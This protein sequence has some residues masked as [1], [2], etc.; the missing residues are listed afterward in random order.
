[1]NDAAPTIGRQIQVTVILQQPIKRL[2]TIQQ[3]IFFS[4]QLLIIRLQATMTIHDCAQ[5]MRETQGLL[6]LSFRMRVLFSVNS[7][8]IFQ[9]RFF[10]VLNSPGLHFSQV[11]AE[12]FLRTPDRFNQSSAIS[13]PSPCKYF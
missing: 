7:I 11:A 10:H 4:N 5:V 12:H 8:F 1:M 3:A 2:I 13:T 9:V 6:Y